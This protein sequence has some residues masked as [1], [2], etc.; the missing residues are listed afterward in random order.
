MHRFLADW[1][2]L[3]IWMN[4]MKTLISADGLEKDVAGAEAQ[5]ERHREYTAEINSRADSFDTCMQEGQALISVGHPC[6]G[7]I[8][9]KLSTLER[10]RTS[11]MQLCEERHEQLEQGMGLQYFCRD[12]EQSESWIGKQEVLSEIKVK[13]EQLGETW[14][15]LINAMGDKKKNL[16]QPN[17]QQQFV[18]NVED[19]E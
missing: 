13:T 15:H 2:D 1:R 11:L 6:S 14:S 17:R 3:S 18:R 4:D 10:E 16:D 7:E 5:V 9:A 8:A 12:D 19:V